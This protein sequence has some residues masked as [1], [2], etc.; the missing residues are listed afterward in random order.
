VPLPDVSVQVAQA[1]AT[2]AHQGQVDKAGLAYIE[3]PARVV[4]HLVEP[5]REEA[6]VAWLHDV[7]EDT[8]ICLADIQ[9]SFGS[10]VADAVDAMTHRAGEL[11]GDYYARVNSNPIALKVKA[12][13]LA[14]NTDP[15]RLEI[16]A[17]NV[18]ARLEAKYEIARRELD[19]DGSRG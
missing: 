9:A 4:G 16:L 18:R 6:I 8:P 2:S 15:L 13:D 11:S 17:S 14:D 3:H 5:S 12:A 7:V 1:M 19:L 10:Q